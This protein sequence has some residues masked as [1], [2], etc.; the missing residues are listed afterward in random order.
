MT[1]KG[2]NADG[3]AWPGP[4]SKSPPGFAVPGRAVSVFPGGPEL[5]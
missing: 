2:V 3:H 4:R 5:Y 1:M